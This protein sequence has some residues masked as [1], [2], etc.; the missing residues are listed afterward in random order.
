[1]IRKA[2]ATGVVCVL[3]CATN[4]AAQDWTGGYIGINGGGAIGKA[5]ATTTVSGDAYF[6][7]SSITSINETG[8]FSL[9]PKGAL[10]GGQIGFNVQSG[11]GVFGIEADFGVMRLSEAGAVTVEYPCCAG[12]DYTTTQLVE[13]KWLM[14]ARPR[15]GFATGNVLVYGTGGL[16]V[17]EVTQE[18]GFSDTFADASAGTRVAERRMGWTAGAGLEVKSG[19]VSFKAEYLYAD[20]GEAVATSDNFEFFG[21][22]EPGVTFE[23]VAPLKVQVFRAGLNFRF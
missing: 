15:I 9:K 21:A 2:I 4:A 22:L 6:A 19:R 10:G 23:H 7:D 14:T 13:T 5:E 18:A 8:L 3:A 17:T 16:A 12:T 20:F 11:S 1:M